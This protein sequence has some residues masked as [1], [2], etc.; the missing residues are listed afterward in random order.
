MWKMDPPPSLIN[1]RFMQD[2]YTD[3][4]SHIDMCTDTSADRPYPLLQSTIDLWK[5][6][7]LH[8][9]HGRLTPPPP[10]IQHRSLADHYTDYVANIV[11]CTDTSVDRP[12]P[13]LQLTIDLWRTTTLTMFHI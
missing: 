8:Q 10:P 9:F 5:T 13:L 3:Y 12:P 6:T 2:N 4:I 7:T 11:E 1:H